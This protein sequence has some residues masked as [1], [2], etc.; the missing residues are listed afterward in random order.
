MECLLYCILISISI[1]KHHFQQFASPFYWWEKIVYCRMSMTKVDDIWLYQICIIRWH[2]RVSN[3]PLF[4]VKYFAWTT[5]SKY[6]PT[7]QRSVER[8]VRKI[9]LFSLYTV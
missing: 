3:M 9:L 5:N 2:W 4:V 7:R 8:I 6:S 1:V